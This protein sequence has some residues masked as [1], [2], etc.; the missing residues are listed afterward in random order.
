MNRLLQDL[1][2]SLLNTASVQ[3]DEKWN[4]DN[5]VSPFSRLYLVKKG[6]GRV[7]HHNQSFDLKEGYLY[8]VPSFTYSRYKCDNFMEQYYV[9]FTEEIGN[10]LSIYNIEHF[11]YERPASPLEQKLYN[12]LLEINPNR[13]IQR[14]D[15]KTYD[16]RAFTQKLLERNERIESKVLIETQGILKIFLSGFMQEKRLP[17]SR[18][19][20]SKRI[21]NIL[22]YI[23]EHLSE[24]L[25]VQDLADY[26]HLNAD[27]F[28]RIFR[29]QYKVRPLEF[30][31]NKRIERAQLLLTTTNHSLQEI[32]HLVGLPNISYFNRLFMRVSGR[33]PSAYRKAYWS[34]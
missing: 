31:Q 2:L 21:A 5:V 34:I 7:F 13:G 3:L 29:D 17:V 30:I 10:G 16:N 20:P 26:C 18:P 4:Y 9:H 6:S 32:A 28:S 33:T 19:L 22:H 11:I 1:R 25:T 15:P 23:S 24:T 27:Y 12:R 14:P 8:L